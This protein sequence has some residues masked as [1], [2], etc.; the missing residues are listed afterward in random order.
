[1]QTSEAPAD[2]ADVTCVST[3]GDRTFAQLL[4]L[5]VGSRSQT[6]LSVIHAQIRQCQVNKGI[7]NDGRRNRQ[8]SGCD[9]AFRFVA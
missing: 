8:L 5:Q 3:I 6:Q 9:L 4:S 7:I 1:M 2:L